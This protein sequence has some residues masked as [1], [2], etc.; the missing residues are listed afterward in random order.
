MPKGVV[1]KGIL[2]LC[3]G[4]SCRSQMAEG[5]SKKHAPKGTKIWSAGVEAHGLNP[6]A[7]QVMKEV[8][9][10]IS[11][12]CSKTVDS[13]SKE[14]IDTVIT[15]CGHA[16]ETCPAFMGEVTRVHWEIE[17]PVKAQG[18]E[19]EILKVFRKIRDQL[20]LRVKNFFKA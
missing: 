20:E 1:K 8:G 14:E 17:D 6:R 5:F 10:N 16:N 3:T 11:G 2:F 15:V 12:Q 18:S 19:D 7:V 13:I 9:V 4:N